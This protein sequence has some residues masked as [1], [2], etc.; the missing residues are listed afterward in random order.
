MYMYVC[1]SKGR[2]KGWGTAFVKIKYFSLSKARLD[3]CAVIYRKW[4]E[5]GER[6]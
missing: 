5:A 6:E 4:L 1:W 3:L 2:E